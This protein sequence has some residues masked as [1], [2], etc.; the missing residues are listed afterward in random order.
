MQASPHM[1][2]ACAV[3][4]R[5]NGDGARKRGSVVAILGAECTPAR[6][7]FLGLRHHERTG[8]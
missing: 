5:E 3:T 2:T 8:P 1:L 6:H 4:S 7:G